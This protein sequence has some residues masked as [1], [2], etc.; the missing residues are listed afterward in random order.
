MDASGGVDEILL[1]VASEL[2]GREHYRANEARRRSFANIALWSLEGAR[3]RIVI[4][5]RNRQNTW[6]RERAFAVDL[7]TPDELP[8]FLSRYCREAADVLLQHME[9]IIT[10]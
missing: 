6:F 5:H 2:G 9:N 8:Y 7:A 10:V 4:S 1:A 3:K